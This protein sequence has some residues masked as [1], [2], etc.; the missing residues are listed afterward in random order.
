MNE[1]LQTIFNRRSIRTFSEKQLSDEELDT[2]L[3]AGSHAPSAMNQQPWHF[4]VVQNKDLIDKINTACKVA[5]KRPLDNNVSIFYNAPTLI[6]VSS[7]EKAVAP[8]ID[9]AIA[10]QNMFLAAASLGIGSCW[11]HSPRL[12]FSVEEGRAL[13]KNL[14]I[15]EGYKIIGSG[16]FGYN[17]SEAP[18]PRQ[19]KENIINIIK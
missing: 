2:I 10:L 15:P 4:T 14:G 8:E 12:L 3:K 1:T 7:E 9:G 17:S 13:E 19:L 11:I 6:I 16:V 18:K 5:S